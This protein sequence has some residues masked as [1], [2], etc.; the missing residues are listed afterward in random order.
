MKRI[1]ALV[2]TIS[3]LGLL[4]TGSAT[5]QPHIEH[6]SSGCGR[7]G[8]PASRMHDLSTV[9]T[10]TGEV[11]AV[12]TVSRRGG[13]SDGVHLRV[14]AQSGEVS[15]HLGPAWYLDQQGIQI[16]SGDQVE[17]IGSRITMTNASTIIARQI[18]QGDRVLTL[19]DENGFPEWRRQR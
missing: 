13:R 7:M 8:A 14:A 12:D 16:E 1:T 4:F 6:E 2:T 5:A 10:I 3:V 18:R 17:V 11:I 19:R 15:V 9:E